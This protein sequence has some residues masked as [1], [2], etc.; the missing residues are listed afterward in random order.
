MLD[1]G[2]FC[3]DFSNGFLVAEVFSWYYPN[4]IQLHSYDNGISLPTKLGNWSQLERASLVLDCLFLTT[5][6]LFIFSFFKKIN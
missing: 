5:K 6:T 2:S 1:Q 3:R 4:D